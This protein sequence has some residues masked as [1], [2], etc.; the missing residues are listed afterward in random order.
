MHKGTSIGT[1][2]TVG[3]ILKSWM[4][5][6]SS[7]VCCSWV[8]GWAWEILCPSMLW[9]WINE[10]LS[11][12]YRAIYMATTYLIMCI[13]LLIIRKIGARRYRIYRLFQNNTGNE[14]RVKGTVHPGYNVILAVKELCPYNG[15]RYCTVQDTVSVELVDCGTRSRCAYHKI[16]G[17]E[18]T[19]PAEPFL[20]MLLLYKLLEYSLYELC[21]FPFH[22]VKAQISK[23]TYSSLPQLQTNGTH[24]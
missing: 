21:I 9:L 5:P 3:V 22:T 16:P 24:L 1:A 8:K 18:Y 23:V 6:A 11:A 14:G 13:A 7:S 20:Q 17:A 2:A 4:I 12:K 15:R 10:A 19:H